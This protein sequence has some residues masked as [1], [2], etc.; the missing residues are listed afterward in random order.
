[1]LTSHNFVHVKIE[2]GY[3]F[4]GAAVLVGALYAWPSILSGQRTYWPISVDSLAT[5]K[6]LRTHVEVTGLVTLVRHESDGDMHIKLVGK[7]G[8]IVAECVPELPCRLPKVGERIT[9]RGIN[10]WDGE[11]KWAEVHVVEWMSP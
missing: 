4:R 1:M 7:T 9:V 2:S 3:A 5:G 11:H 6:V 8:F 10:R